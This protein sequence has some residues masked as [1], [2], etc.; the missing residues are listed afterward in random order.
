MATGVPDGHLVE[1][2]LQ[3]LVERRH[4]LGA[5]VD[6][7]QALGLHP[8]QHPQDVL[9]LALDHE[10][11]RALVGVRSVEREQVREPHG[12]DAEVG[13]GAVAPR[14]VQPPVTPADDLDTRRVPRG[15]V[16]R[17]VHDGVD[18]S[19]TPSAVTTPVGVIPTMASVTSSTPGRLNVG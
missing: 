17:G 19:F 14:L 3:F 1:I 15:L 8:L 16:A 6:P 13:L 18:R 11:Q 4:H 12:G 9:H 7:R 5:D 2:A 10:D